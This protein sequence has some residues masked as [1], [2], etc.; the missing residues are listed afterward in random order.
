MDQVRHVL[1]FVLGAH[2]P[3][4][5]L[6]VDRRWD[7]V[8]SNEAAGRLTARL[9]DQETAPIDGG[10]NVAR[11]T[12]HPDGLRT[13]TTNWPEFGTSVL[14][15][16]ERDAV[17][18]PG[19]NALV[20]LLDEVLAY[21]DVADLRNSPQ[22]PAGNDLLIPVHYAVDEFEVRLMSTIST[23]GAP[24]DVTLE[25]LRLETFYAADAESDA[26][27]HMLAAET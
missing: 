7:V 17:D 27:L 5:A 4:P 22:L 25:E 13:V 15:R 20:Q 2:E 24:Y 19:D 21:P 26:T 16:L 1:E 3:Y 9:I 10:I 11:L 23:I 14:A 6:V 8:M 18:R 12:F